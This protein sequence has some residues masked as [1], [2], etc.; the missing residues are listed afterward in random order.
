MRLLVSRLLAGSRGCIVLPALLL[1]LI[2]ACRGGGDHQ[3]G[4][5][6]SLAVSLA[7]TEEM[8]FPDSTERTFFRLRQLHRLIDR[9]VTAHGTHPANL[10][11][12]LSERLTRRQKTEAQR[13]AWGTAIRMEMRTR[14]PQVLLRSAGADRAWGTTDDLTM[15]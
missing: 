11:D 2:S 15:Q 3:T 8:I 13:D 14:S 9:Y 5:N 6:D 4:G 7:D 1:A 10:G 12:V